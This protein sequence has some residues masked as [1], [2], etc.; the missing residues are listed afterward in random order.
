MLNVMV[1]L[2]RAGTSIRF[3]PGTSCINRHGANFKMPNLPATIFRSSGLVYFRVFRV[4][5]DSVI[6]LATPGLSTT[7]PLSWGGGGRTSSYLVNNGRST[8]S[9][10]R[11]TL[12][13]VGSL[14]QEE[15]QTA[16]VFLRLDP[17]RK[18]LVITTS[19]WRHGRDEVCKIRTVF[20]N[21]QQQP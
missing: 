20:G 13:V 21:T 17:L 2:P 14:N 15:I 5:P 7:H 16:L 18:V 12:A 19:L 4:W 1:M 10:C 3:S 6:H 11:I 8:K 9:Q